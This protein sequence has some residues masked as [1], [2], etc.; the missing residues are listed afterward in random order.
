MARHLLVLAVA[1]LLAVAYGTRHEQAR[2]R[3]NCAN[4]RPTPTQAPHT[5]PLQRAAAGGRLLVRNRLWARVWLTPTPGPDRGG[6]LRC[7]SPPA[8]RQP[9]ILLRGHT[10]PR[11]DRPCP[12]AARISGPEP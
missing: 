12:H 8:G 3:D 5:A 2:G 1:T 10:T 7:L 6:G 11:P 4:R 9:A